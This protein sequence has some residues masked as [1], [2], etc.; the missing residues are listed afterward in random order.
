MTA[1]TAISDVALITLGGPGMVGV[2]DVLGRTVRTAAALRADVLLISQSS[3]QNDVCLVIASSY[4]KATVEALRH[5][6]AHDLAHESAEHITVDP[7]VAIVAVVG[8]HVRGRSRFVSRTFRAL[9]SH[10]VGV[11]AIAQGST[12]CSMSFVVAKDDMKAALLCIHREFQLGNPSNESAAEAESY[13]V[14]CV[15][16]QDS[17][18][19]DHKL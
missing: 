6:F 1:L 16:S 10:D 14:P 4:A 18:L 17:R 7:T 5:E 12:E 2:Q 13:L 15:S 11:V 19:L 8:S 3:S 9:D